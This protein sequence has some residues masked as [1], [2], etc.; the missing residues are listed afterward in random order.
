MTKEVTATLVRELFTYHPETG[1]FYRNTA[2]GGSVIGESVGWMNP[3]G[4]LR[5]TINKS[6]YYLHRLAWIHYYGTWP[7]NY[8]DHING[9]KSDNRI[10]NLRESSP[11]ENQCN[12]TAT[13][14]NKLGHKNISK[15]IHYNNGRKYEYFKVKIDMQGKRVQKNFNTLEDAI[16]FRDTTLPTLHKEFTNHG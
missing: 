6:S 8:I 12:R 4:Y 16:T 5:T 15:T 10:V 9:N 2:L 13:R 1:F 3:N 11:S 14:L 7:S